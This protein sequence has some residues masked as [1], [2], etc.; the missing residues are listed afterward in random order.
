MDKSRK[1]YLI[2]SN[3]V[4]SEHPYKHKHLAKYS[5]QKMPCN[6]SK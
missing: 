6:H 5:V 4:P 2:Y 1:Q 3:R